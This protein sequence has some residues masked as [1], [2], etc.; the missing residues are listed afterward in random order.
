MKVIASAGSQEKIDYIKSLGADVVFNYKETKVADV[1]KNEGP[2]DVYW[3]NVGGESLDA[4]LLY[5]STKARFIVSY[6]LYKPSYILLSD[7]FVQE[8]GMISGY[9]E[10]APPIRV[11]RLAI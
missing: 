3:D 10:P 11:R 7:T 2:V 8:C 4:A 9:N 6:Y 1:L 5:S